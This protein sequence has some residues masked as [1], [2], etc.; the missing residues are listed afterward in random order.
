MK[1]IQILLAGEV[2]NDEIFCKKI[3]PYGKYVT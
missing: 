1:I 2:V 3:I